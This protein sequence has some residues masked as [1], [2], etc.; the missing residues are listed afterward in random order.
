MIVAVLA[1]AALDAALRVPSS[2]KVTVPPDG[3]STISL[4][5][6]APLEFEHDAPAVAVQ[7]HDTPVR[8]AGGASV[9]VAPVMS[10]GPLFV[11]TIW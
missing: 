5:A 10:D 8:S 3:R 1:T 11:A 4:I 2:V 9:I 7:A 6:P